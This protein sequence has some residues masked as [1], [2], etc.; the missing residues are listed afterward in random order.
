MMVRRQTARWLLGGYAVAVLLLTGVTAAGSSARAP[1]IGLSG[2]KLVPLD[3][4][5][6]ERLPSPR[7]LY[8]GPL[9]GR[10]PRLV[11][12]PDASRL[13]VLRLNDLFGG[14]YTFT[15]VERMRLRVLRR[16]SPDGV[17]LPG[18]WDVAWS[19]GRSFNFISNQNLNAA[20]VFGWCAHLDVGEGDEFPSG[21]A[22]RTPDGLVVLTGACFGGSSLLL[23]SFPPIKTDLEIEVALDPA[24]FASMAVDAHRNRVFL[25][26]STGVVAVVSL[27]TRRVQYHSVVLPGEIGGDVSG[28]DAWKVRWADRAAWAGAGRLAVWGP[29][30]LT[31]IDTRDWSARLVDQTATDVA[32][33]PNS[34]VSWSRKAAT[35]LTVYAP[36]GSV[37][38]RAL[39]GRTVLGVGVSAR[40]AYLTGGGRFSVDL[41][42][43]RVTGPLRSRA[44]LVLPNL[45]DLP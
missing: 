7:P 18:A 38:F 35:G 5:T 39:A 36:D 29:S 33:A 34:V 43:G 45:L 17:S 1:L 16:F 25:V 3:P 31:L 20:G 41:R 15:V 23:T 27:R 6:L 32:V 12:S 40:Y 28:D 22:A 11:L 21:V 24:T 10:I 9:G 13:A 2:S 26:S 4:R 19:K 14:G 8:V 42:S 30:G 44:T 37:R